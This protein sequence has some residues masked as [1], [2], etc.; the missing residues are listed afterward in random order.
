M[1]GYGLKVN[2]R[3][4]TVAKRNQEISDLAFKDQVITV[5]VAVQQLYWDL[6][7]L[8]ANRESAREALLLAEKL[9]EDNKRRVEIGTL[10]PIEIVRAEAEV[11]LRQEELT[12]AET[13][14]LQQE[15]QIKNTISV[16]GLASPLLMEVAIIPTD[17]I[18]VPQEEELPA[19]SEL[20]TMALAS[21]PDI[22]Q[23]RI[24]LGSTDI[25]L[26][27]IRNARRPRLDLSFDVTNNGLAGQ[28]N[29]GFLQNPDSPS[30][31]SDFFLGGLGTSLSQI[32]RRNFPDYQLGLSFSMPL[33][34]RQ[35]Q[36]DLTATLLEKRQSEIRLRQTENSIRGEVQN[37]VIALRQARAR[38]E[39]SVKARV[40]QERTL[41]A[42]QKK[43]DLGASTIFLVVQ[44]QRDLAISRSQEIAAMNNYV[45]AKVGLDQATGHTLTA[46]GISIS[47][48]YG[49][50]VQKR[51]DPIPAEQQQP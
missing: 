49:G 23:S 6:V 39:T 37:A 43:F 27:A 33:R 11:A 9:Y 14:I 8:H 51:P 46:N 42:E 19:A 50:V 32:F 10:A 20:M 47:E 44:A 41:D 17:R 38:Y 12:I 2:T 36:A 18:Q 30:V 22:E 26:K 31:L 16:N 34:N 28:E 3:N 48:A 7:S 4:I 5:V 25:N 24:R 15:T 40:L 35:S 1:R 45:I 29:L 13:L 21:R